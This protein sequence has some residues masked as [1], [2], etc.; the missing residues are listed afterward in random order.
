[1]MIDLKTG[2]EVPVHGYYY[3]LSSKTRT[4]ERIYEGHMREMFCS[5]PNFKPDPDYFS[6]RKGCV[7]FI[8]DD[9]RYKSKIL[10]VFREPGKVRIMKDA[11]LW[12]PELDKNK[13][14][15]L[16]YKAYKDRF[17]QKIRPM[18]I[19]L[20]DLKINMECNL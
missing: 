13:A 18:Q 5:N 7:E 17:E 6:Y 10:Y 3:R 2:K 14:Y 20:N 4:I 15:K 12:L 11:S 1:M 19:F 16:F 9:K 8:P